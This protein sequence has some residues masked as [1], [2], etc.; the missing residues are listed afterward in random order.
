LRATE[1]LEPELELTDEV[2][3]LGVQVGLVGQAAA[4][5]IKTVVPAGPE[6]REPATVRAEQHLG[7]RS[8]AHRKHA[9]LGEEHTRQATPTRD[10]L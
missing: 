10:L 9:H 3:P 5:H 6:P 2:V 4:H 7:Q 1:G 8:A